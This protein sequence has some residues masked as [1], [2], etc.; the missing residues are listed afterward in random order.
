[1]ALREEC[2]QEPFSCSWV[3]QVVCVGG[4]HSS[5]FPF[6]T[7]SL[8]LIHLVKVKKEERKNVPRT[9]DTSVSRVQ[10]SSSS[11][12]RYCSRPQVRRGGGVS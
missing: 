11:W 2:R 3:F 5:S 6:R 12:G 10:S 7:R 1:M 9:R 4:G 8:A